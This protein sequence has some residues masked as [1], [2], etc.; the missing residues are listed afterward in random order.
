M[1]ESDE[2][3]LTRFQPHLLYDSLECFFA[4]SAEEWT[5]NPSNRLCNAKGEVIAA[6]GD[7]LS[8]DFL[9]GSTYPDGSAAAPGDYI[10]S[11]RDDYQAQYQAI[12]VRDGFRNV[13]YGRAVRAHERLWLQYWFFYFL[14][15]YQLAWG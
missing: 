2:V 7:T 14:N 3:L 9:R 8:L 10:H 1:P 15:D 12:R 5:A 4:D 13:V 11:T 6:G